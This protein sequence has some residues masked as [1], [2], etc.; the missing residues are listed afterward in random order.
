[1]TTPI[2]PGEFVGS[3]RGRDFGERPGPLVACNYNLAMALLCASA[4]VL[5]NDGW[6]AIVFEDV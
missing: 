1:M 2:N 4:I 6:V 3:T 5:F